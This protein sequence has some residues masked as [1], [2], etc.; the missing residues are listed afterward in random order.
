MTAPLTVLATI[1]L[2][3]GKSEED[4]LAASAKFEAEFVSK[5]PG[6]L[7]R[8]LVRKSDGTYLDI[9]QFRSAEDMNDVIELEK[10]SAVCHEFFAVMDTSDDSFEMCESLQTFA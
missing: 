7:R 3:K 2:A 9:V 10:T 6:V 5:Q 1:K 4:L 8:E